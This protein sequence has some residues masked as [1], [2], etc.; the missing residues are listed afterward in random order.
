MQNFWYIFHVYYADSEFRKIAAYGC[1]CLSLKGLEQGTP[2]TALYPG[3][4]PVDKKDKHCLEYS[5]EGVTEF[6]FCVEVR[7]NAILMHL[8]LLFRKKCAFKLFENVPFLGT[9]FRLKKS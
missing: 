3:V 1:Y 5:K 8:V 7:L 4:L 2:L 6:S 9:K